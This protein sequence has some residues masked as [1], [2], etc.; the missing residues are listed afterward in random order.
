MRSVEPSAARY[1]ISHCAHTRIRIF[2]K[3][4][5]S[6]A[7]A[8]LPAGMIHRDCR[9]RLSADA[10]AAATVAAKRKPTALAASVRQGARRFDKAYTLT[11]AVDIVKTVRC[12]VA[13]AISVK[14]VKIARVNAS[15]R[16]DKILRRTDPAH[17]A[18]L[19]LSSGK[20]PNP[21]FKIPVVNI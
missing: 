8:V 5:V 20:Y 14:R 16:F 3:S 7:E 21:V 11:R 18:L 1:H 9:R 19:R 6:G 17:S 4:A 13:K 12:K 15:V 10:V 2:K